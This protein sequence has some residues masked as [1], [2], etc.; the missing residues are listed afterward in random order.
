MTQ[1][2][3]EYFDKLLRGLATKTDL[4]SLAPKKAL[5][6]TNEALARTNETLERVVATLNRTTAL[7]AH[8]TEDVRGLKDDMKTVKV[9][10]DSHTTLLDK[11]L[12]N[13]EHSKTE[14]AALQ[15]AVQRH[16]KWITQI[17]EKV[18]V[19]LETE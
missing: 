15:S 12:R 6:R 7:V 11:I 14:I 2:T 9:T 17:A 10:L 3:K 18:D 4:R 1:L 8:L 16:E 13:T 19:K 5:D